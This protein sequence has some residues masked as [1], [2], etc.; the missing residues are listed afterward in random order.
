MPE[1]AAEQGKAD[2]LPDRLVDASDYVGEAASI[3]AAARETFDRLS[4]LAQ[5]EPMSRL[6]QA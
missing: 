2:L 3:C 5:S 1:V 4:P 6:A